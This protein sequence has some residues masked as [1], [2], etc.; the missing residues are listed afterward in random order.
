[1]YK[2]SSGNNN[3]AIGYAALDK[4]TTTSNNTAVGY[5]ALRFNTA[6]NNSAFGYNALRANT[7]GTQNTGIG[8][9]CLATNTTGDL[10]TAI[11]YLAMNANTTGGYNVAVGRSALQSNT[12][13][14]NNTAVGYA[15]LDACTTSGDNVAVG[16][17]ALSAATT[18]TR[19]VGVGQQAGGSVTTGTDNTLIGYLAGAYQNAITTGSDNTVVGAYARTAGSTSQYEIVLGRYALGQGSQTAS[20][21]Y[22]GN[23]VHISI[24]GSTS[25]WSTH[26]DERLKKDV[27]DSVAG[28]SFI[29][30]LQ[31]KTFKWKKRNE[32]STDLTNHYNENSEK[33]IAGESG[34][35]YHGFIAQEVKQ[36][37]ENHP[38]IKDGHDI[39]RESPDGVQNL[40]IGAFMPMVI[41]AIQE[42]SAKCDSL[43]NEIN[44]LK[45]E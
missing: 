41:K 16:S 22:N 6:D 3:T 30:D 39:W 38:E 5:D 45:G 19:C 14:S 8:V 7:G 37:I 11:G 2:N 4:N 35:T 10:N 34:K 40:A 28:L 18:A 21:G 13:A 43:Q 20:L 9:N 32:L 15:A 29:N 42:L 31:P 12:S 23:G 1:M 17:V 44:I 25:S 24:T 36:I 33:E 26:S 27:E